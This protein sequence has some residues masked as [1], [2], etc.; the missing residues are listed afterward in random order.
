VAHRNPSRPQRQV[1]AR[2]RRLHEAPALPFSEVLDAPLIEQALRQE[3]VCFR[4]RVFSPLVTLWAFLSQCLDPDHSC[5]QAVARVLA[6]R[7]SQ[8]LPPCSARTSSYCDARQ[9]LPEGVLARLTRATARRLRDDAPDRR[10][11]PR[12]VVKFV[13][14]T[15]VSMPDTPANQAEYPQARTQQP[16]VGFPIARLVALFCLSTG[17]VLDALLGPYRGKRTSELALFNRLRD[18]L[19]PGDLLVADRYYCSYWEVAL[20]RRRGADVVFR[21]HQCR[22]ADFRR[23]LRLGPCDHL[24]VWRRPRRPAW[25]GEDDY[26]RLPATLVVRQTRVRVRQRGFRTRALVVV[27][28]LL[29]EGE[30][31]AEELAALYRARW[32]AELDLRWLKQTLQM[33]VLRCQ[34]PAMVRKEVW[35]HLLAYNVIRGAMA[36]AA[37]EEGLLPTQLS[38]TAALQTV[39]AFA[40]LAWVAGQ[41]QLAEIQRRVR[42]AIRAHPI[43]DRPDRWEPR[44]RKRRPKHY[45]N[46]NEPRRKARARLESRRCG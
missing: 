31:S 9:R 34:S 7:T 15:T 14:G 23:G 41:E 11:R 4:Q 35:A 24:V 25:L 6:W 37:G 27:T 13:D 42:Q 17:A 22:A 40:A 33:D 8:G 3:R 46:L 16:G 28:T 32:Q 2:R 30:A 21:L 29:D 39:R 43:G 5:R 12:R 26:A 20:A 18:N 45:P 38:F 36:A 19:D 44:A 10:R 1:A